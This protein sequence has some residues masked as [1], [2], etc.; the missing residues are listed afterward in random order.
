MDGYILLHRSLLDWEWWD[1]HNVTRLFIWMLLNANHTDKEWCGITI[2]RGQLVTSYDSMKKGTGLSARQ[3]RTGIDKLNDKEILRKS[4]N[5]YQVITITNYERFQFDG[6]QA[7]SK[8]T[9]ERQTNDKQ[10]TT[11]NKD[12][13]Y[14]IYNNIPRDIS[15]R[16]LLES[17]DEILKPAVVTNTSR[18]SV[19]LQNGATEPM[20]LETIKRVVS[21]N[22][23]PERINSL[24]YFD[25]PMADAIAASKKPMPKPQAKSHEAPHKP[26]KTYI[27]IKELV[28]KMTPKEREKQRKWYRK[29]GKHHPIF[30]PNSET[31]R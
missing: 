6:S 22:K 13:S 20:I 3:I 1:D 7:T 2:K 28:D 12:I 25:K 23:N 11:T 18:L 8:T 17:I 27:E 24:N 31:E 5:K 19:W 14:N 4:T 29:F 9:N 16:E 30:N 15:A 21:K 26:A 10:T